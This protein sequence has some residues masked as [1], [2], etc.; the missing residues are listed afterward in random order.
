M[1]NINDSYF[2][3]AYKELWRTI[4]PDV[5]TVKEVEFMI[6]YF[7]LKSGQKVL[8]LMCGYGRHSIG[9]A[10][11]GIEVTAVDNLDAYINEINN[12]AAKEHLPVKAIKT[13]IIN[14]QPADKYELAICMGNSFNFFDEADA[15][16]LLT[17]ISSCLQAGGYLLIN[18]WSIAEIAYKSFSSSN[19]S[20][21]G[22]VQFQ[23]ELKF[24]LHPTRIETE[25][26]MTTPDG[27][28]EIKNG[29]DYIYSLNEMEKMMNAAGLSLKEVY[30]IPGRKKFT[31]GEPRAYL[32]A[33]KK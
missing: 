31:L 33:E 16:K 21:V 17:T 4:I 18:S 14:Y 29:I 26:T 27:N 12:I 13:D 30:S 32:V 3:G 19:S 23:N 10:K 20:Q 9:L 11:K 24:L 7:N 25:S 5:L 22:D 6:P 1:P 8:D 2:D 28:S 15:L